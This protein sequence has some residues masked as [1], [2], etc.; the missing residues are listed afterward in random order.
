MKSFDEMLARTHSAG[1]RYSDPLTDGMYHDIGYTKSG[2]GVS[3]L[4]KP[5]VT[6][7]EIGPK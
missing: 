7:N 3:V 6:R 2:R 4:R 5:H 1:N